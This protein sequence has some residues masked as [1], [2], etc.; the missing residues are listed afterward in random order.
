MND[1]DEAIERLGELEKQ[2]SVPEL[3]PRDIHRLLKEL[4]A[5]AIAIREHLNRHSEGGAGDF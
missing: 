4:V 1:N 5:E 2:L 3:T